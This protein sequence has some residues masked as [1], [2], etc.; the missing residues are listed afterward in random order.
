MK[1]NL[2]SSLVALM[3]LTTLNANENRTV[4]FDITKGKSTVGLK[5]YKSQIKSDCHFTDELEL[6]SKH[7]QDEW[8]E[9]AQS[10]KFR[11]EISQICSGLDT[12]IKDSWLTNL[13]QFVYENAN[14]SGTV[15]WDFYM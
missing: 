12:S 6:S 13:Y 4:Q 8:Q 2:T 9:I 7:S 1:K 14:D 11:D 10:G 3:L 15:P 5:L